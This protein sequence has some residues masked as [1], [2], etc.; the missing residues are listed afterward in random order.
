MTI[1]GKKILKLTEWEV[2]NLHLPPVTT[3]TLYEGSAPV[4]FLHSRIASMLKKNPWLTSRIVKK[5]TADGVVAMAFSKSFEAMSVID[6]H[7]SVYKP[8]DVG[9]SLDM[10]Y[11]ELVHSLLPV[12]CA[13]SKPATDKNEVLFKVAV[14]PIEAGANGS[15]Q[16]MP[17][18]QTIA[19]PGF[20]LVVSM[21]HTL[22][23][24]HTYYKL[25]SML[26]ADSDVNELDP[27]R[28]SD[29]EVAKTNVIG[30]RE[31][32]MFKSAGL[33]FGIL[34]TYL[35]T[36][37]GR[38]APQNICINEVNPAWVAKEKAM[39]K[40]EGQAPFVST[41]DVLS[42][43]FF[44]K[45]ESEVN[46]MVANFRS[47][48]PPVLNLSDS[49]A[50]NYEANLPYFPGDVESPALIRQSI[51]DADGAFRA[52]RAGSPETEIP[53]FWKL[54]RNKTSIITNWATFY[55]DVNLQ[56]N[57]QDNKE[58]TTKPKLH[59]PIM[60]PDGIIT[61]VWST[62]I[63]FRPRAGKIGMLMITRRFDSDML[64]QKKEQDGPD[65]PL[66]KRIV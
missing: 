46:I 34:G 62:A 41:N 28:V 58:S 36:K 19:L 42:S 47:R 26:S 40:L 63:I 16:S 50:G 61:S 8:G 48:Q 66:G 23:D 29:F 5:N 17:L 53:S 6:Q 21:N 31:A 27:V 57:V 13:R 30:K 39:A 44:R 37:I 20:A 54:L 45:M 65:A 56:D 24:G 2:E 64:A 9:F 12:Q 43:W 22:G 3:V 33:T 15:V 1:E 25:Y 51:R 14:V 38:R 49:H 52:N 4:K 59:L 18:Q 11:E 35:G 32:A 7:F 55:C 10:S 60:E